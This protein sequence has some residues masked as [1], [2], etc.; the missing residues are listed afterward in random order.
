M[1]LCKPC[2]ENRMKDGKRSSIFLP[3]SHGACEDCGEISDCARGN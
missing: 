2:F 3:E 1:F